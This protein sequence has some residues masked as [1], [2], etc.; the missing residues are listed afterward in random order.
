MYW[1]KAP[2][3][4]AMQATRAALLTPH[5]ALENTF[6]SGSTHFSAAWARSLSV[7]FRPAFGK[8]WVVSAFQP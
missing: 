7:N 5:L 4:V 3:A 2:F 8:G 1:I 6:V